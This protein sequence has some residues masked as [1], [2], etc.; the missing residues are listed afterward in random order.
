MTV[1]DIKLVL[2]ERIKKPIEKYVAIFCSLYISFILKTKKLKASSPRKVSPGEQFAADVLPDG[3]SY[4]TLLISNRCVILSG[5]SYST[6]DKASTR[7]K[8][9]F[10]FN[11]S[12]VVL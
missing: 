10:P 5:R 3:I 11:D 8:K 7:G 6:L 9:I 1:Q 4:L 12:S 2:S